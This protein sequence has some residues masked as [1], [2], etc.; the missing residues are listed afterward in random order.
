[1]EQ[2]TDPS[3]VTFHH[4]PAD[5]TKRIWKTFWLLLIVTVVEVGLGLILF[6]IEDS[7]PGWL[8][9]FFKGMMVILTL[10]KAFYIVSIFMHLGDELR[11]MIMTIIVPLSLF[12]WFIGAFLWDGNYYRTIRNRYDPSLEYKTTQPKQDI[13]DTTTA[14]LY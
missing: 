14:P 6:G 9:L 8:I 7:I 3:E 11:N 4:E 13:K 5:N 10:A 12:I 1:M 2:H